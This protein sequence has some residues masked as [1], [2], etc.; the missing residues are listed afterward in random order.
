MLG[1]DGGRVGAVVRRHAYVQKRVPHRWFDVLVWPVVDTVI[2][3]SI[4]RFVDQQGGAS[5]AGAAYMLSGILLMH[6][7]YQAS[8]SV[9]TGFLE[10]TWSRNLLNLMVT[11]LR[12]G[13]YLLGVMIVGLGRLAVSMA[14]VGLA[15]FSLYAFD[16]TEAGLGL[17]PIVAVLMVVGWCISLVVIALSL[18]F[19][20]GAEIL[21]WGLLFIVIALSGAF[22][23][24]E[25]VP[26]PLRPFSE[27]LPS[28]HALQA[29]R[30][31]LD[32]EPLP[33]GRIG[34]SVAGLTVLV[35]ATVGFL[36][37]MLRTFGRRGFIT[38]Y[39]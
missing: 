11:P 2:W 29:A 37:H 32:G 27:A 36:L 3:G 13:E 24:L 14:M 19:G 20:N 6:V 7:L 35:P 34:L 26:G 25:A 4:G 15:A 8:I 31:L 21:A 12:E 33:W 39:S 1:L 5:R 17:L 38:R 23:P 10:E 30:A 22:Y 16:V 28:T 18:R 9:S